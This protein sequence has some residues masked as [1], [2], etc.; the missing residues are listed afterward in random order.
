MRYTVVVKVKSSKIFDFKSLE[1]F[2]LKK[3][4]RY[5]IKATQKVKM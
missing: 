5:E 4:N 3:I 2:S 1:F